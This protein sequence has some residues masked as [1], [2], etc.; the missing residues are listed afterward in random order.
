MRFDVALLPF[1]LPMA[2]AAP[3]PLLGDSITDDKLLHIT[4]FLPTATDLLCLVLTNARFAAKVIA[5]APSVGSAGGW[6]RLVAGQQQQR[7]RCGA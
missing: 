3:C 2:M 4:R 1:K 6:W 5:T 7:R